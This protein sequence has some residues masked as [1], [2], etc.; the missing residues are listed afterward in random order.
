ML[1]HSYMPSCHLWQLNKSLALQTAPKYAGASSSKHP[2]MKTFHTLPLSLP[3]FRINFSCTI[4]SPLISCN[5]NTMYII[6]HKPG[7]A[8][9]ILSA[10]PLESAE[11]QRLLAVSLQAL[12]DMPT[13]PWSCSIG[14]HT[15][16]RSTES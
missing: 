3:R 8:V 9:D 12:S 15:Q 2:G 14:K 4:N 1:G 10:S 13:A 7:L 5:P 11:L 16:S 6:N